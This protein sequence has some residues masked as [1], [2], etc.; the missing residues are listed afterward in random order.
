MP[1][2]N[3]EKERQIVQ[4]GI[5]QGKNKEFIT[6]AVLRFREQ[7]SQ[8]QLQEKEKSLFDK[9]V[10]SPQQKA[11][12]FL[13]GTT[14]KTVGGLIGTGIESAMEL[15]GKPTQ[16]IFTKS[17]QETFAPKAAFNVPFTALE[18]LPGGAIAKQMAKLPF[19]SKAGKSLKN[20][21]IKEFLQGLAPTK[22]ATKITAE[23]IAPQLIKEGIMGTAKGIQEKSKIK[24]LE[25]GEKLEELLSNIPE[26]TKVAIKPIIDRL[27]EGK[28]K[29]IKDGVDI[30]PTATKQF[31]ELQNTL[32]KFGKDVSFKTI[33]EVRQTFDELIAQTNGFTTGI[34]E[35]AKLNT[36]KKASDAIREELAKT[37]PELAKIN[38]EY[39]LWK[40]LDAVIGE[41]ILR[42]GPQKGALPQVSQIIG[43][44]IGYA[45]SGISG[46]ILTGII[47][48]NFTKLI[49]STV[50]KTV[51][52][53]IKN[54]IGDLLIEGK[55][56][57]ALDV[58]IRAIPRAKNIL[59]D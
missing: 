3:L 46:A 7:Q 20:I 34:K 8:T 47:A 9:F 57:K 59:K 2:I 52:A 15:A 35:G 11:G 31:T 24:L 30:Y 56:E 37:K 50:Y 5:K 42:T 27:Q 36:L 4:E 44:G 51:S 21:A 17:A 6:Q 25:V 54:K 28:A 23:K 38:A 53:N 22:K 48:K 32:A 26:S 40:R 14:A 33:R 43:G 45:H 19:L 55:A 10:V 49:N 41:T 1:I 16:K 13:F 39:T 18:L 58:L 12:K 29:F